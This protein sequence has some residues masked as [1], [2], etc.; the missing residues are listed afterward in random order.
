MALNYCP[1]CKKQIDVKVNTCPECGYKTHK[2]ASST[3]RA[4]LIIVL[5]IV[6][7]STILYTFS[8]EPLDLD[9]MLAIER[10]QVVKTR[11]GFTYNT[12]YE[13]VFFQQV[14]S[15]S[16]EEIERFEFAVRIL[17]RS[18]SRNWPIDELIHYLSITNMEINEWK[19]I[20]DAPVGMYAGGFVLC[21]DMF[22]SV[23]GSK[24]NVSVDLNYQY[25]PRT[26]KWTKKASMHV[27]RMNVAVV[28]NDNKIYAIG[29]DPFLTIN[30]VYDPISDEWSFLKPMPT[31]SQHVNAVVVNGKIY[32]M[33]GLEN[34]RTVSNKN[35]VYDIETDSWL[36]MATMPIGKHNYS[37]IVYEDKIYV[38]GGG[39]NDGEGNAIWGANSTIE[40]YDTILD[41]WES[42]GTMPTSL[43]YGGIVVYGDEVI[44]LGGFRVS[45][46]P[47][48]RVDVFSLTTHNWTKGVPLIQAS[49]A[50]GVLEYQDQL[51]VSGGSDPS[52]SWFASRQLYHIPIHAMLPERD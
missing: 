51:Y 31:G 30:E 45:D 5:L 22:Y 21:N 49:V 3:H 13:N 8:Q 24:G 16:P 10:E 50:M 48:S 17:I 29:G 4:F 28:S 44:I 25:D 27:E 14:D 26:N 18:L 6:I 52:R 1:A 40:V 11:D 12:I 41:T 20:S 38:F 7:I 15:I 19:S 47:E 36:E 9:E 2:F 43:F 42:I 35:R 46:D 32:V 39:V 23:G 37:S 33:G 34:W